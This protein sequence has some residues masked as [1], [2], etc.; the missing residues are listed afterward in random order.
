MSSPQRYS[1]GVTNVAS[2]DPMGQLLFPDPTLCHVFFDDFDKYTA[3]DW[4]IT[5]KEDGSGSA[6]EAIQDEEFGVLKLTNAAGDNDNDF[7]QVS[8]EI[9]KLTAGKKAW[10]KTR[11]KVSDATQSDFI[12]GLSDTDTSPLDS[13]DGVFFYK[14]DGVATLD[15][16]VAVGAVESVAAS[17]ATVVDDTYL[18][19][20]FY[21]DGKTTIAYSVDGT[22][23]GTL[24]NDTIPT[25]E[26]TPVF[27]IQNGEAV[28]KTMSV[29]Y[30]F[31]CVER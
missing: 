8:S 31:A 17:I 20:A 24:T 23:E 7:L 22:Q 2:S 9:L 25:A 15:F 1:N 6:T 3:A 27:G 30:L 13:S 29:D 11:I 28:A 21:Y 19:L 12:V 5:T 18:E 14:A 16:K 26:I 10:F 4:T